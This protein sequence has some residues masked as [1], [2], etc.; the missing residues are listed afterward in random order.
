VNRRHHQTLPVD[1]PRGAPRTAALVVDDDPGHRALV[2]AWLTA[3]D[4]FDEIFEADNGQD[5]L[6]RLATLPAIGLLVLDLHMPVMGGA[7]L[8]EA[9]A[10]DERFADLPTVVISGDAGPDEW[11][12]LRARG[13]GACL[14]KP[15]T[16]KN[17]LAAV[18]SVVR[19]A[20]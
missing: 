18:E 20:A 2:G 19:P 14:C 6:D 8:L 5:A 9:L 10:A 11:A 3:T 4:D 15:V 13:V 16:R 12:E 7:E 17:V 1:P